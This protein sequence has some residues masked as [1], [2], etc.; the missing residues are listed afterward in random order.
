MTHSA[1]IIPGKHTLAVILFALCCVFSVRADDA[2]T[3]S[4]VAACVELLGDEQSKVR[5]EAYASLERMLEH[6]EKITDHLQKFKSHEDP[7]IATR[8]KGLLQQQNDKLLEQEKQ[9]AQ[10]L[11]FKKLIAKLRVLEKQA[12]GVLRLDPADENKARSLLKKKSSHKIKLSIINQSKQPVKIFTLCSHSHKKEGGGNRKQ[13]FEK[14][15]PG[16]THNCKEAWE[17]RV[18]VLTDM[19]DKSL[20]LYLTGEKDASIT[21]K[22]AA[23]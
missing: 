12:D 10:A 13:H 7:E 16:K 11:E 6:D 18:Y 8:I 5:N 4:K 3:A 15:K 14:L 21:L 22:G 20:G 9:K 19:N 23:R 1:R 2:Q 17:Q